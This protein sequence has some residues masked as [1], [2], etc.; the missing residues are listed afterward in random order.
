MRVMM[1]CAAAVGDKDTRMEVV[2]EVTYDPANDFWLELPAEHTR[3]RDVAARKAAAAAEAAA[4]RQALW[5]KYRPLF[6]SSATSS[7][8]SSESSSSSRSSSTSSSSSSSPAAPS[9]GSS[10]SPR[11]YS[12]SSNSSSST[13][14]AAGSSMHPAVGMVLTLHRRWAG[15]SGSSLLGCVGVQQQHHLQRLSWCGLAAAPMLW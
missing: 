3:L 10:S 14:E 7:S 6:A 11:T 4:A 15:S 8:S 2:E 13:Q 12:S 1:L 5:R 9:A